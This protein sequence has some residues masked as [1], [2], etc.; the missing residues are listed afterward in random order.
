ME[1]CAGDRLVHG[2]I[3]MLGDARGGDFG[4]VGPKDQLS[5]TAADLCGT[6]MSAGFR[7]RVLV[8]NVLH[9]AAHNRSTID[10][11]S[12]TAIVDRLLGHFAE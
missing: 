5:S 6:P 11:F 8:A 9:N 10:S 4:A 1:E 12:K 3:D 2:V 7:N